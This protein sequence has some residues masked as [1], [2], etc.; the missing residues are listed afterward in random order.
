MDSLDPRYLLTLAGRGHVF[1]VAFSRSDRDSLFDY[2]LD[3]VQDPEMPL[4]WE[5][6]F[7]IIDWLGGSRVE[8]PV[9]GRAGIYDSP[10]R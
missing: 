1:L 8:E 4:T 10:R 7:S 5:D 2:L 9:V 6:F 3:L